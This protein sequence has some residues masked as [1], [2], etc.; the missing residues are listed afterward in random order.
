M[1]KHFNVDIALRDVEILKFRVK[2]QTI[3]HLDIKH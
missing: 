1:S 2:I 3:N